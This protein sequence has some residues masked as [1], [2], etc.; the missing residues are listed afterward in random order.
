MEE[1]DKQ[2]ALG[3]NRGGRGG[4]PSPRAGFAIEA[5]GSGGRGGPPGR[6]GGKPP[7]LG[8]AVSSVR[9]ELI[10]Q[11]GEDH[12]DVGGQVAQEVVQVAAVH[13]VVDEEA[14]VSEGH[15]WPRLPGERR[16]PDAVTSNTLSTARYHRCQ[17]YADSYER[18][19]RTYI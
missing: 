17:Y 8:Q 14:E 13:E 5:N 18:N 15:L 7:S 3:R 4:K 2:R 1:Q 12:Q 6:G 16:D 9:L 10:L 19:G 11:V